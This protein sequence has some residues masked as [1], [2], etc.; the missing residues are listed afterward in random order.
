MLNSTATAAAATNMVESH[1][2]ELIFIECI[3]FC[4]TG[5]GI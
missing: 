3:E 4:C 2:K 5:L 1:Y